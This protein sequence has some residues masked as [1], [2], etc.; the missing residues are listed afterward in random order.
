MHTSLIDK[1]GNI[2][3]SQSGKA[4]QESM[5]KDA[6]S[7]GIKDYQIVEMS[8]DEH[9]AQLRL[10]DSSTGV[11]ASKITLEDLTDLVKT[12]GDN[13]P[14]VKETKAYQKANELQSIEIAKVG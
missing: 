5:A 13:I 12:L 8:D 10:Q 11:Q 2:I 9:A 3:F 4:N 1:T 7:S 14:A 6:L